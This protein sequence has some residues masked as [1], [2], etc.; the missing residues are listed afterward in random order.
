MSGEVPPPRCGCGYYP[1]P[2]GSYYI[3]ED[4]QVRCL[5]C[6]DDLLLS[7][8]LTRVHAIDRRVRNPADG[9]STPSY[10]YVPLPTAAVPV[11]ARPAAVP[12]GLAAKFPPLDPA[13]V[14]E[15]LRE[16]GLHKGRGRERP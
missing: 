9:F 5:K 1:R 10:V 13:G 15:R 8:G 11:R 7:L 12:S 2:G 6:V 16:L 14:D 4:G 3:K